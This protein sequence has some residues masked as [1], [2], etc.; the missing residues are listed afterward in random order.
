MESLPAH[1]L[2][3]P[4]VPLIRLHKRRIS[5][6]KSN[7]E[8]SIWP[9]SRAGGER[10]NYAI[11]YQPLIVVA[12]FNRSQCNG[13]RPICAGCIQ[14]GQSNCFY[15]PAGDMRRTSALKKRIEHLLDDITSLRNIILLLSRGYNVLNDPNIK[16]LIEQTLCHGRWSYLAELSQVIERHAQWSI[17][18][19]TRMGVPSAQQE[20][21]QLF[22]YTYVQLPQQTHPI[23]MEPCATPLHP[24]MISPS[25][26]L[27]G[28]QLN[29]S[30]LELRPT[31]ALV[32]GQDGK[33]EGFFGDPCACHSIPSCPA[34]NHAC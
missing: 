1:M 23:N 6:S 31:P 16:W 25:V 5:P 26:P 13:I 10:P 20:A 2:S 15:D 3:A 4:H 27:P 29:W 11:S 32:T 14:R 22:Q 19:A 9:V 21:T 7:G 8:S 28:T 24:P 34:T 33:G 18:I 12:A 30:S 17:S